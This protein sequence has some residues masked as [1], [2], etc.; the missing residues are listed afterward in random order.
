DSGRCEVVCF[1]SDHDASFA[2]LTEERAALVLAAWTDR[3][4]ELSALDPVTQVFCFENRGAEIG[5]T[6]GH[7]HGQIYG[8]P[9]VTPRTELMLASAARHR[10][11]TGGNLFDDVVAR[12]EKDGTRVVLATDHWIAYVPY[13]AHWPYEVHL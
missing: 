9:F 5:V 6:L 12:E 1:T 11:G 13:A 7:P 8:Y 10:A 3:T 2:S 4:A